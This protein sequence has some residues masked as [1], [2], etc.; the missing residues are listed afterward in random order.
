MRKP[1]VC[2]VEHSFVCHIVPLQC[3]IAFDSPN[4]QPSECTNESNEWTDGFVQVHSMRD[5]KDSKEMSEQY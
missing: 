4:G 2:S 3:A 1:S 5:R